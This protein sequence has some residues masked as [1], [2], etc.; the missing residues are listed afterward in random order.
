VLDIEGR[1]IEQI[2][3]YP[4]HLKFH[5]SMTLFAAA[6]PEARVFAAALEKYFGGRRDAATLAKIG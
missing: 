4:D 2:F 3:G 6:E 1:T 5:S